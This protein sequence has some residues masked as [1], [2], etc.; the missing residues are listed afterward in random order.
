MC[1]CVCLLAHRQFS[2]SFTHSEALPANAK[3]VDTQT[4]AALLRR[5][6]RRPHPQTQSQKRVNKKTWR[7]KLHTHTRIH[8][9]RQCAHP[10]P[11]HGQRGAA[12]NHRICLRISRQ[13]QHN[14]N[15]EGSAAK[16][17]SVAHFVQ[18]FPQ[19]QMAVA[20]ASALSLSLTHTHTCFGSCAR[21]R[22][23]SLSLT[24]SLSLADCAAWHIFFAS[25]CLTFPTVAHLR[26][27]KRKRKAATCA[28]RDDVDVSDQ[29]ERAAT[30]A[31]AKSATLGLCFA[32][33]AVARA[34]RLRCFVEF[35][36]FGFVCRSLR[37]LT[38]VR[39]GRLLSWLCPGKTSRVF[40]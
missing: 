13:K 23:P 7:K 29:R 1:E 4:P 22:S 2:T 17:K 28:A 5:G 9:H 35:F 15:V 25:C 39:S 21:S 10:A 11:A 40:I 24:L 20:R 27:I 14:E 32:L 37:A 3:K 36:A 31:A 19:H 6:S 26:C 8:T 12:A 18:F 30:A 38:C 34:L 33:L 16:K